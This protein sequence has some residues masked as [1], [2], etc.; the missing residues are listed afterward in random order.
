[1]KMKKII[2]VLLSVAMVVTMSFALTSCGSKSSSSSSSS[3][4]SDT[5]T[6][7]FASTQGTTHAWYK[8]AKTLCKTVEDKTD[9]KV[10]ITM[11]FGGV[12]GSDTDIAQGVQ[13]GTI[14]M[15]IGSTV[16]FNTVVTE[17]DWV[18]LPYFMNSYDKVDELMYNKDSWA[19]KLLKSEAEDNGFTWLGITDCDF[20][21]LSTNKKINSLDDLSKLKI[22]VPESPMFLNF[23]TASG[24]SP[25]AMAITEVPSALQQKTIDGQDNGPII[26]YNN[27]FQQFNKYW[28][29]TNHSFAP[30]VVVINPNS[31]GKLSS[32]QQQVLQDAVDTYCDS[33]KTD[34]RKEVVTD[35]Q[36]MKDAGCT[37]YE[38]SAALSK[39]MEEAA[40]KVWQ[41]KDV[42][43]TMDQ[44]AVKQILK[45]AGL[46]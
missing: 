10:K 38:P 45:D 7:H 36:K 2:A 24:A 18:N 46:S 14:D 39:G 3:S 9:G 30:A 34:L 6:L 44:T 28:C 1:M 43:K 13:N 22:R 19:Y 42:T 31:W 23:F 32:D 21:W 15:Y 12:D 8:E 40:H 33:V 41:D 26:S 25:T 35:E 17:C 29:K 16:G 5:I 4:S 27:G 37:V 11:E 20:R